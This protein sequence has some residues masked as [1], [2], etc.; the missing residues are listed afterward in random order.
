MQKQHPLFVCPFHADMRGKRMQEFAV[1]RRIDAAVP[2]YKAAPHLVI[3]VFPNFKQTISNTALDLPFAH[4]MVGSDRAIDRIER[5]ALFQQQI[6]RLLGANAALFVQRD[7][8]PFHTFIVASYRASCN[9]FARK[10]TF[11]APLAPRR[12]LPYN[13]GIGIS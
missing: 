2:R 9:G 11:F 6:D 10:P 12:V 3:R 1:A 8:K 7:Q 5:H 13:M 4:A